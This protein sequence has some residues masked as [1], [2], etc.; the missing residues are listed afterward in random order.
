M[1]KKEI[2]KLALDYVRLKEQKDTIARQLDI[3]E[4]ELYLEF[5]KLSSDTNMATILEGDHSTVRRHLKNTIDVN[6]ARAAFGELE[7]IAEKDFIELIRPER[8]RKVLESAKVMMSKARELKKRGGSVADLLEKITIKVNNGLTVVR[9][10][11]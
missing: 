1:N 7:N 8:E 6:D 5:D 4:T 9:R 10:G 3:A 11:G 2:D